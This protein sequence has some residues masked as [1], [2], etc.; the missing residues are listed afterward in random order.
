MKI[1]D[2][3]IHACFKNKELKKIAK[4]N[5]IDF[6][7]EGL[8][9]EMKANNVEKVVSISLFEKDNEETVKLSKKNKN[10]LP[11]FCFNIKNKKI[12]KKL[13]KDLKE[14]KFKAIKLYPGYQHFYPNNKKC[15]K[16]Y[17]IAEKFGVPII[18]HSGD[19][20]ITPSTKNAKVKYAH[21]LFID[22]VAVEHPDLKIII[23]HSG[24]PWIIDASEVA[25]KNENVFLDISGWFLN[26]VNGYYAKFMKERLKFITD[27]AGFEKVLF[28]TDWP[29]IKMKPYIDFVKSLNFR[30]VELEKIFYKN[31]LKLFW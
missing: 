10:L 21:P 18:F 8:L 9:K 28:G 25:Y 20:W 15:N 4:E 5:K 2:C 1:I 12:L 31:A 3:H 14:E 17:K 29:L 23:A 24:N 19:V 13:K 6:S 26:E 22:D 30:K 16:I 27:Y 7:F 11:V